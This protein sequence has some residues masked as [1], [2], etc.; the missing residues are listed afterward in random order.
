[1]ASSSDAAGPSAPPAEPTTMHSLDDPNWTPTGQGKQPK[2]PRGMKRQFIN[3]SDSDDD[4]DT[5]D[6]ETM[7]P[8]SLPLTPQAFMVEEVKSATTAEDLAKEVLETAQT[9]AR[10]TAVQLDVQNAKKKKIENTIRKNE[11]HRTNLK[12]QFSS[13]LSEP[14][15]TSL[16]A[17]IDKFNTTEENFNIFSKNIGK[18]LSA[19]KRHA[20]IKEELRK[21]NENSENA[22]AESDKA[23]V[24]LVEAKNQ[25]EKAQLRCEN[26]KQV[27][28]AL[29]PTVVTREPTC[30]I[31]LANP[32][33][34]LFNP[35]GCVKACITCA[36]II[37][38]QG[39][40]CPFCKQRLTSAPRKIF[41]A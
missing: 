36:Q 38:S 14:E 24:Q 20:I 12:N 18:F 1:M 31:C 6:D 35:C 17:I 39:D 23:T 13:I 8:P 29:N 11:D 2:Q 26:L 5:S 15:I 22:K 33:N 10:D 37:R 28:N 25:F 7:V 27:A 34:A 30:G 19:T 21:A 3:I 40:P 41:L 16:V 32:I 9:N 4:E